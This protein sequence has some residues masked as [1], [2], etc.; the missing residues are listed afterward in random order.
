MAAL[1]ESGKQSIALPAKIDDFPTIWV[2]KKIFSLT[3]LLLLE[4]VPY[5]NNAICTVLPNLF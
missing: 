3:K 5:K 1:P 2:K 4:I